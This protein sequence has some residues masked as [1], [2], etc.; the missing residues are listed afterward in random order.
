MLQNVKPDSG[1]T[2]TSPR[3]LAFAWAAAMLAN[4]A[5]WG[6]NIYLNHSLD[7]LA[8]SQIITLINILIVISTIALALQYSLTHFI[9]K[10]LI[11]EPKSLSLFISN[12]LMVLLI[13]FLILSGGVFVTREV[14]STYLNL[15]LTHLEMLLFSLAAGGV[16]INSFT[17]GLIFGGRWYYLAGIFLAIEAMVK[18]VWLTSGGGALTAITI[19]L[20][21]PYFIALTLIFK[22]FHFSFSFSNQWT[23]PILGFTM[24]SLL[25]TVSGQLLLFTDLIVVKHFFDSQLA[26]VY[27]TITLIGKMI[28]FF[29]TSIV[30]ILVPEVSS[31]VAANTSAKDLLVKSIVFALVAGLT[32]SAIFSFLPQLSLALFLDPEKVNL[33]LPY[34]LPY[35]L[36][37]TLV[38]LI[39]IISSYYIFTGLRYFLIANAFGIILQIILMQFFHQSL[40]Q[41]VQVMLFSSSFTLLLTLMLVYLETKFTKKA[42]LHRD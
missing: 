17:K 40:Q 3:S 39:I 14:W 6:F 16:F 28:Y 42:L 41:I 11:L 8:F 22:R 25:I 30:N 21:L 13:L 12:S 32:T 4:V 2:T 35:G 36:V 1:N 10:I 19:S 20:I 9:P 15:S 38:S 26:G 5:N 33:A 31:R 27:A 24:S 7:L 23:M 29:V 18:L 34:V 37:A